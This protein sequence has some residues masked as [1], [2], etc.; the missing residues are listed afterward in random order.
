MALVNCP[1]CGHPFSDLSPA[2]PKCGVKLQSQSVP[3]TG[4]PGSLPDGKK[5]PGTEIM[6]TVLWVLTIFGS[7]IGGLTF[8]STMNADSAPKQAAGAAI[9]I[10]WAALPYMCARAFSELSPARR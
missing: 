7:V 6:A 3:Q 10:A 8:I 4:G 9:S 2:C 1:G 5:T